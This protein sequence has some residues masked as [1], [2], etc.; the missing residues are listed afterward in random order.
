MKPTLSL[1]CGPNGAGK[2]TFFETILRNARKGPFVNPDI[3]AQEMF[4]HFIETEEEM[5]CAQAE[6]SRRR[7][8][9]LRV[10]QSFTTETVF[11]HPSKL[12]L[13][14]Q[15]KR[16][17]FRVEVFQVGLDC[18]ERS[19]ARVALRA[20]SQGHA[21]PEDLIRKRFALNQ[22][23][24]R[25]A[26]L[27]ADHGLVFDNSTPDHA[28]LLLLEFRH[29]GPAFRNGRMTHWAHKLYSGPPV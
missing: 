3:I 28:L 23:L 8:Q 12:E 9:Y 27:E 25:Q 1:L 24:I 29:G 14:A 13:I 11:S 2:T 5:R 21:V 15:A 6:A 18:A 4:G 10:G 26:V 7:E 22:P 19:I 16:H 20:K 17:G